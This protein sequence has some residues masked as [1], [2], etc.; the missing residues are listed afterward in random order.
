MSDPKVT[1]NVMIQTNADGCRHVEDVAEAEQ[2]IQFHTDEHGIRW[3][4]VYTGSGSHF[5]NWLEQ[6]RE[7]G[8]VKVEE[9][10][11]TGFKCFE[12]E[13][14]KMYRIWMTDNQPR[15]K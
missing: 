14:G 5:E 6:C 15:K 4:R 11:A 13:G 10:P 12:A 2:K 3:H 9:I 8:E 1:F 7:L